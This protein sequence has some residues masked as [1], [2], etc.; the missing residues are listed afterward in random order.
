MPPH[1]RGRSRWWMH[2]AVVASMLADGRDGGYSPR[3]VAE[4]LAAWELYLDVLSV[5]VGPFVTTIQRW[6]RV[7]RAG[8]ATARW[9]RTRTAFAR[10]ALMRWW[11]RP[12]DEDEPLYN[13]WFQVD[14]NEWGYSLWGSSVQ[15]AR[16][17]LP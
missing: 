5:I 2:P 7:V 15:V 12:S 3:M 4:Q 9:W 14:I 6:W 8:G 10:M 16:I 1:A 17:P 13:Q 11:W